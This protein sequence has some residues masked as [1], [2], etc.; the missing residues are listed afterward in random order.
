MKR[1]LPV[2]AGMLLGCDTCSPPVC[3]AKVEWNGRLPDG[4]PYEGRF[5]DAQANEV[6][7]LICPVDAGVIER[8]YCEPLSADLVQC[9]A[10]CSGGR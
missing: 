3:D 10:R 2:L 8:W 5:R 7:Q 1:M 6:C 9:S 4:G